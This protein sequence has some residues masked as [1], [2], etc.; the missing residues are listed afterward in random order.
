MGNPD[1]WVPVVH[2]E[3][4]LVGI[5]PPLQEFGH[6]LNLGVERTLALCVQLRPVREL[7]CRQQR[8]V[9]LVP[10]PISLLVWLVLTKIFNWNRAEEGE[11]KAYT[12]IY[13]HAL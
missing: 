3:V 9:V 5:P 4:I 7:P 12:I 1:A 2:L 10:L 11:G 13:A 6:A 8:A